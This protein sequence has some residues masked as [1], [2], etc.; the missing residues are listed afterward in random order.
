MGWFSPLKGGYP[1]LQQ[2]DKTLDVDAA[3]MASADKIVRGSLVYVTS[4]N[5][6]SLA[7]AAQA[8]DPAALIH[9]ALQGQDDFQAGM[10][11]S[12]GQGPDGVWNGTF[13]DYGL[14]VIVDGSA[15]ITALACTMPLEFQTDQF[16]SDT[17]TSQTPVGTLLTCGTGTCA[18][19]ANKGGLL[20]AH[21]SGSNVVGQ[22]T[23]APSDRW[24]NDA[25]A[26]AGRRTGAM[27]TVIN[28]RTLW[29]PL[30]VTAS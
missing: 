1:S 10:A 6:F 7:G 12:V 25:V 18:G 8:T 27:A 16:D 3:Q 20:V 30:L 28:V 24:V 19:V 5:V 9:F 13:D 21:A 14:G 29:L 23:A 15:R 11:G 4:D 26:V 2:I 17:I 22:L